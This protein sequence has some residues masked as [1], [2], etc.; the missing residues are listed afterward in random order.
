MPQR[1]RWRRELLCL[2]KCEADFREAY[3][4]RIPDNLARAIPRGVPRS[5]RA[6]VRLQLTVGNGLLARDQFIYGD[7][8][9]SSVPID[10]VDIRDVERGVCV[11]RKLTEIHRSTRVMP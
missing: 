6:I 3:L 11:L 4:F 9:P 10:P 5:S 8:R 1:V 2:T 7:G